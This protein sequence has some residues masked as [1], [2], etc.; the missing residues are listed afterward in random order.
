MTTYPPLEINIKHNL[1]IWR[2]TSYITWNN[3]NCSN[4]HSTVQCPENG[5][6]NLGRHSLAHH[7]TSN[8]MLLCSSDHN[9]HLVS[10]VKDAITNIPLTTDRSIIEVQWFKSSIMAL[11]DT[12]YVKLLD[13]RGKDIVFTKKHKMTSPFI[14]WLPT[15]DKQLLI[16]DNEALFAVLDQRNGDFHSEYSDS[17]RTLCRDWRPFFTDNE[18]HLVTRDASTRELI[19]YDPSFC[20]FSPC[21]KFQRIRELRDLELVTDVDF[22]ANSLFVSYKSSV[23]REFH[24]F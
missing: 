9:I 19:E 23:I 5:G 16:G 8:E 24:H 21:L 6:I 2:D 3:F 20:T 12:E 17:S 13:L 22:D 7:P 11:V 14:R 4:T 10:T 15:A 1:L 18:I